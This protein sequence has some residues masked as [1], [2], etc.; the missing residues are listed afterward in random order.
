MRAYDPICKKRDG[1][2]LTEEEIRF[3]IDGCC[4]GQNPDEQ[5]AAFFDGGIFSFDV[6]A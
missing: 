4:S 6:T 5:T 3:F 1:K 2:E